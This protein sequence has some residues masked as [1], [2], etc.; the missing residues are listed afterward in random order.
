MK[1]IK[2]IRIIAFLFIVFGLLISLQQAAAQEIKPNKDV[3]EMTREEVLELTYDQLL[4]MPLE[5]LLVLAD[6]VGVSMDEL[7][8]LAMNKNVSTASKQMETVFDSPLSTSVI[9]KDEIRLSGATTIEEALRLVPGLIVREETNGNYDVHIRGLDNVPPENFTHFSENMI[10]LVMIDG[11]P[12]YNN[13]TGGTFWE[14][15][16]VSMN[17]VERIDVIRGASSA[18]YGPNAVSGVINI[19]TQTSDEKK[20]FVDISQRVGN[21]NS[22][23]GDMYA[24]VELSDDVR[25]SLGGKYDVR[26]RYSDKQYHFLSGTYEEFMENIPNIT[27][28]DSFGG[29][30]IQDLPVERAKEL[31]AGNA[32]LIYAPQTDVNVVFSAGFQQS[33]IQSIFFENIATPFS[34]RNSNTSFA[35]L[36]ANVKNLR[37]YFAYQGGRQDLSEGM[38]RPVIEYDMQNIN[39]NVEY[40]FDFGK[41]SVLPG[42]NYQYASYDDA[43]Y[44]KQSR[45]EYL[46]ESI[47]GL[48]GGKQFSSLIG[49]SVRADYRPIEK[50]RLIAAVRGDKYE[51]I[52]DPYFSYQFVSS[53]KPNDNNLFRAVYSKANRGAFVGDFE[54]NFRNPILVGTPAGVIPQADY[55]MFKAY[56]NMDPTT[57]ALVSML[58]QQAIVYSDFSQYYIGANNSDRDLKLMTM[59]MFEVGWRGK[60]SETLQLEV[61]SFL[62]DAQ[63]FDALV[64]YTSSDTSYYSLGELTGLSDFNHIP[65]PLPDTITVEEPLYYENLPVSAV[66]F[67]VSAAVNMSFKNKMLVKLFGTYQQTNLE[68]HIT[69]LNENVDIKHKNTPTFY[70]GA[71]AMYLPTDKWEIYLGSYLYTKQTYNRYYRPLNSNPETVAEAQD[72]AEARIDSKV[73]L[74]ARIAYKFW[75][76]SR[77][78]VEGK[79]LLLDDSREFGFGDESAGLFFLGA[80]LGL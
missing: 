4:A 79:N 27:R 50:L 51:Y 3:T 58:P 2:F 78:F 26:N 36:Q 19:V 63:N 34:V 39:S 77:V 6:I 8:Q 76:N 52:D 62:S 65:T 44:I 80:S 32:N 1:T 18:L 60:I 46:D 64:P 49:G 23:I 35:S 33:D 56:L 24:N 5:D 55:D 37:A 68:D 10:S 54:A 11:I 69:L 45:K 57:A 73:I 75:K 42:I 40:N 47:D 61:E 72:N 17:Q 70:G 38:I 21:F 13:V 53:F 30:G 14:T 15:L 48:F 9:T 25:I 66:Q 16:P 7:L 22:L 41:L 43:P 31:F 59:N 67:G 29:P 20:S 28:L 71:S 12:V 74:N